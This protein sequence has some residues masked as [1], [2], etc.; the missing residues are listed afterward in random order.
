M[1]Y[2]FDAGRPIYLQLCELLTQAIVSGEYTPGQRLSGVRELAMQYGVNPNTAQRTMTE[3]ERNGLVYSERTT[4]RFVTTD[5][6]RIAEVRNAAALE[7]TVLFLKKMDNLGITQDEIQNL[8]A[9]AAK[10][11]AKGEHND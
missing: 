5:T 9:D 10:T 3:L 2:E 1:S 6:D 4:G 11:I 7:Q 8:L